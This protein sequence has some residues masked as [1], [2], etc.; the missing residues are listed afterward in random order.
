[1]SFHNRFY[2]GKADSSSLEFIGFV[3]SLEHSKKLI[4]I[5]HVKACSIVLH[6]VTDLSI[7]I[8]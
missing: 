6:I 7:F 8:V 1:M 5:L 2:Q 3:Q 4:D